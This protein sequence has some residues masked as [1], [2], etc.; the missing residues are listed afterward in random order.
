[1]NSLIISRKEQ[2]VG[3]RIPRCR[4]NAVKGHVGDRSILVFQIARCVAS[5][6]VRKTSDKGGDNRRSVPVGIRGLF[7]MYKEEERGHETADIKTANRQ[8]EMAPA[9]WHAQAAVTRHYTSYSIFWPRFP[10]IVLWPA[11]LRPFEKFRRLLCQL[12]IKTTTGCAVLTTGQ[13]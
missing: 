4:E 3:C 10:R 13:N 9:Q 11:I 7:H 5:S 2:A 6:V 12:L 1:M 8:N